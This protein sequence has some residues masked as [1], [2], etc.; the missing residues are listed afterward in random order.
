MHHIWLKITN[1]VANYT[2]CLPVFYNMRHFFLL[3]F[4]FC[5]M[6]SYSTRYEARIATNMGVIRIELHNDTPLHR[7]NFVELAREGF[8]DGLLFHRVIPNFMIQGGDPDSRTAGT[9]QFLGEGD[10]QYKIEPEI[11]A[12]HS[13]KKG[14]VAAARLGDNEN[15][16]RLSSAAQFYITVDQ[17]PHLDGN[18]TIFGQVIG[19]QKTADKIS[20]AASDANDRPKKDIRI[21]KITIYERED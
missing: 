1:F 11:V 20:L 2:Y 6:S 7:D 10:L 9:G 8:Y 4:A 19:G 15:P 13:H 3:F 14:A 17:V 5:T 12:T 16:R 21:K 18:Y